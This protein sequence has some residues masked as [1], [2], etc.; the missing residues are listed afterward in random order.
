MYS[1]RVVFVNNLLPFSWSL[2]SRWSYQTFLTTSRVLL[3]V[4]YSRLNL[5]LLRITKD[6]DTGKIEARWRLKGKPRVRLTEKY[7]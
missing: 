3:R 4:G 7:H 6:T 5:D 1:P 2:Y